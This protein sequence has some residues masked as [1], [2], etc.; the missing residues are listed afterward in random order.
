MDYTLLVLKNKDCES[1]VIFPSEKKALLFRR[2][3]ADT[4]GRN[5]RIGKSFFK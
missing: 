4:Q 2:M 3:S 5:A 1:T